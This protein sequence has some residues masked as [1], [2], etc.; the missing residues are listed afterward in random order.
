MSVE[1]VYDTVVEEK[2]VTEMYTDL[3]EVDEEKEFIKKSEPKWELTKIPLDQIDRKTIWGEVM[4]YEGHPCPVLLSAGSLPMISLRDADF[5]PQKNIVNTSCM[6]YYDETLQRIYQWLDD[7]R[8]KVQPQIKIEK[9][10]VEQQEYEVPR[11]VQGLAKLVD[12]ARENLNEIWS[13]TMFTK[14][15]KMRLLRDKKNQFLRRGADQFAVAMVQHIISTN[16]VW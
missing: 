3:D 9:E 4:V 7:N 11:A 15:K 13:P 2:V 16:N 8:N 14:K 10:E 12:D 1:E 5:N 6:E